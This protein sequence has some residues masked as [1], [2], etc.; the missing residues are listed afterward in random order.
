MY[1]KETFL[2]IQKVCLGMQIF[3][4]HHNIRSS[5][6]MQMTYLDFSFVY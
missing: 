4:P 6:N 1:F 5:N 2:K 3:D